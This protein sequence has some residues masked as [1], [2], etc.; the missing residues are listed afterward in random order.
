[1][2]SAVKLSDN[3]GLSDGEEIALGTDPNNPDSDGD[4]ILDGQ[5]V[6]D[7]TNPLDD[8][9]HNGGKAL[10]DSDCDA[11]GLTT[12]QEDAI[13]SDPNN[14]DTDG[15]TIPDGQE[16]T[17]GT[18]PLDP[19]DAIGGVPTLTA[20]CDEEVVS[21]GIAV[22]NE[23]LTPDNDGVNDFFR[24]EN[25]ESFP[26][27]TVQIYNRWGVVVYEMAGYDNQSN[28]FRGASNGRV[29]ISTDSELPVGVYFYIIKYVNEGN[30]LN[31]AGYLYINR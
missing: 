19:C 26:N 27:N 10:P 8:C 22:S 14:A 23:I 25:I 20:G 15:D 16:I 4:G 12:A 21:S 30:H 7:G 28:V 17:D 9:D 1:M 18:D 29:T 31:K 2:S 11:D 13:G 5:E 24:I 6:L 3:D